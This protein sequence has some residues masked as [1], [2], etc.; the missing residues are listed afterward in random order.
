VSDEKREQGD[1][2]SRQSLPAG[3]GIYGGGCAEKYRD[4]DRGGKADPDGGDIGY[5]GSGGGGDGCG[6]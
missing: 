3:C 6:R 5:T 1:E 2:N 4:T